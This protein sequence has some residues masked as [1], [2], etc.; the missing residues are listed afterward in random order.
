MDRGSYSQ[1]QQGLFSKTSIRK[2]I[3]YFRP[4]DREGTV[5]IESEKESDRPATD[6]DPFTAAPWMLPPKLAG[7]HGLRVSEHQ[8]TKEYH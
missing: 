5:E 1:N 7:V 3:F 2:G 6:G 4:L 8:T